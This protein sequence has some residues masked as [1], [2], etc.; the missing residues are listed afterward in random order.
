[1]QPLSPR[2]GAHAASSYRPSSSKRPRSP[3]F[4]RK[5]AAIGEGRRTLG[6]RGA[7]GK[8]APARVRA[9]KALHHKGAHKALAWLRGGSGGDPSLQM[10]QHRVTAAAAGLG[11]QP[12]PLQA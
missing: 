8:A 10:H 3:A 2:W 9:Q 6:P 7:G 4:A 1:M 5:G 12:G 11:A